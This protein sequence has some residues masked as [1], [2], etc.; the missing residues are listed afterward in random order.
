MSVM[1]EAEVEPWAEPPFVT[2][3][4]R[5]PRI[6]RSIEM[7]WGNVELDEY[8]NRLILAGRE[9]REGFPREVMAALMKLHRQHSVQFMFLDS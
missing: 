2:I 9:D 5:Y 7:L 8:L 6:A 4:S 3:E 1:N